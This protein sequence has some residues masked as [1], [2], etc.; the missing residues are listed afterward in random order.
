[1]TSVNYVNEKHA[2]D[3][4]IEGEDQAL[5]FLYSVHL[6]RL[7]SYGRQFSSKKSIVKD[8]IQDVFYELID[9]RERISRANSPKAY[10]YACLRRRVIELLN[11]ERPEVSLSSKE[12]GFYVSI[13]PNAFFI[14]SQL[15]IDQKKLLEEHCNALPARQREII[16]MRFFEQMTYDEIAEVLG[17]ANAKTVRTM[18]YRGLNK[19]SSSL[20]PYRSKL[21][22]LFLMYDLHLPR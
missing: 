3:K 8:A 17:L 14:D 4:F 12:E 6:D 13:D 11:K 15:S 5:A 9:R 2:W 10:I 21:L 7:Y 16:I 20:G 19:L 18:M 1:M 22:L